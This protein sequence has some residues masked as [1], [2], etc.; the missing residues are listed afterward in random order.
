MSM[1]LIIFAK[2]PKPGAVKTRLIPALGAEGAAC[3]YERLLEHTIQQAVSSA[4]FPV[5]L[6]TPDG[7]DHPFIQKMLSQ[8]LLIHRHQQGADLG[9]RMCKALSECEHGALLIGSDCPAINMDMLERCSYALNTHEA[10]FLPAVDGGYT[11]VGL[12]QADIDLRD[13]GVEM[14]YYRLFEGIEWSTDQV[15]EQT[16][17]R[18]EQLS[19]SW[20]EPAVLWDVD[21]PEDLKRLA[22]QFPELFP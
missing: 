12:K 17:E 16:R 13:A 9:E 7:L 15:M 2:A 6:Y 21:Q 11:L 4:C 18:L 3:L 10:V 19:I 20:V 8:Y 14:P 1:P 22:Q 5:Y